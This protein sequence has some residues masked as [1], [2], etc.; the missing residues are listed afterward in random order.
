MKKTYRKKFMD[1]APVATRVAGLVDLLPIRSTRTITDEG[2]LKATAAI[3]TVGVQYYLGKELGFADLEPNKKYGV[4]RSAEVVFHQDTLESAKLKPITVTHRGT[5]DAD[6]HKQLAVGTI[7]ETVEQID[8]QRLGASIQITDAN[9]VRAVLDGESEVSCGYDCDVVEQ[10]GMYDGMEYHFAFTGGMKINHLAIVP[11][12]RCGDTVRILD[13]GD[14]LNKKTLKKILKAAGFTDAEVDERLEGLEDDKELV[15]EE[16]LPLLVTKQDAMEPEEMMDAMVK[17]MKKDQGMM[18]K[19][20]DVMVKMMK[21]DA[22]PPAEDPPAEDPP[23]ETGYTDED[24]EAKATERVEVLQLCDGMLP[25]DFKPAGK[26]NAEVM[27]A[28]LDNFMDDDW[29]AEGKSEE[30]LKGILDSINADRRRAQQNRQEHND[31]TRVVV[32]APSAVQMR[33]MVKGG[34]K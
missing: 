27:A 22:A 32:K 29:S 24:V 3:T 9:V 18:Q 31:S 4:Y 7:G 12:G 16:Y 23:A 5:V 13:G 10:S 14:T 17:A 33:K 26:S 28:A 6:N 1:K 21:K 25:E 19:M 11:A 8:A 34:R 30:Y 2:Y 15:P 20:Y